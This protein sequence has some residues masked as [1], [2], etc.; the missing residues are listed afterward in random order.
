MTKTE[1]TMSRENLGE[2]RN[3]KTPWK[4]VQFPNQL[5]QA[6]VERR[7][8]HRNKRK[9]T[10]TREGHRRYKRPSSQGGGKTLTE[11]PGG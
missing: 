8:G 3:K 2:R 9:L 1:Q 10:T 4:K 11:Q 7:K 6:G 5:D